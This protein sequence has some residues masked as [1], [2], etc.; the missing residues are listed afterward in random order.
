[1]KKSLFFSIVMLMFTF[2]SSSFTVASETEVANQ[3]GTMIT[4]TTDA[5]GEIADIDGVNEV[6][7]NIRDLSGYT[8]IR[9]KPN[10]KVCMRLKAN[11]QYISTPTASRTAGCTSRL[12]ITFA[13]AI[14]CD[15][16]APAQAPIGLRAA[17]FLP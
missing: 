4:V 3:K 6:C 14:G 5:N 7:W 10:G 9:N 17:S 13:K 16:T 12:S 8:N 2:V 15:S 11:T 1:M